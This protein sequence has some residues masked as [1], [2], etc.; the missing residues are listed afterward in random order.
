M[1]SKAMQSFPLD[2][3]GI[4]VERAGPGPRGGPALFLD[5]DGVLVEEVGYLRRPSNLRLLPG[6][7][8]LLLA[9]RNEGW[10]IVL[11]TNQSGI[12]RGYYG[13]EAFA[14]VQAALHEQLR[15]LGVRLDLTLACPFHE[16]GLGPYRIA[17]HPCR[18]PNPGM[19][20]KAA[21]ELS[22]DLARSWILGDQASD[23]A[24]GRAAGLA[25][26]VHLASGHG[27]EPGVRQAALALAKPGYAVKAA[28]D[29]HEALTLWRKG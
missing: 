2:A 6:V 16:E 3:D 9:A 23:I 14:A 4:W 24:A 1:L 26:G 8:E 15:R 21:K 11:V 17:N 19:L 13:W 12:A 22:L 25:V 29:L 20:L 18:K 27:S 10:G 7:E 5:R 28:R